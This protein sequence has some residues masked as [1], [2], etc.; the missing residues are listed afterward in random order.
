M[1]GGYRLEVIDGEL[2][3]VSNRMKS[4]SGSNS[5]SSSPLCDP[6]TSVMREKNTDLIMH[7]HRVRHSPTNTITFLQ[8][9]NYYDL[10][11]ADGAPVSNR[12][13]GS[14]ALSNVVPKPFLSNLNSLRHVLSILNH[15]DLNKSNHKSA[16]AQTRGAHAVAVTRIA[17]KARGMPGDHTFQVCTMSYISLCFFANSQNIRC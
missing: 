10:R 9:P 17:C 2:R 11:N 15:T 1:Q 14:E 7:D 13:D 4:R 6:H 12:S 3:N 16:G 5:I 8:R